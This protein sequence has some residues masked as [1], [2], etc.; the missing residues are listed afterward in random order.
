MAAVA[1]LQVAGL[2]NSLN[3]NWPL[4]EKAPLTS[5]AA[6]RVQQFATLAP[7]DNVLVILFDMV[8]SDL[9]SE[10][11]TLD[12]LTAQF[13]EGFVYFRN[14]A[15]LYTSTQFSA[16]SVLTSQSVPSGVDAFSWRRSVMAQSLPVLLAERGYETT[17]ASVAFHTVGCERGISG[18]RCLTLIRSR[19]PTSS[20]RSRR[21]GG[22]RSTCWR[23]WRSSGSCPT[24]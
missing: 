14:A 21:P 10:V 23:D 17:L 24:R 19:A 18:I 13:P 9:F 11:L 7:Q 1:L 3:E 12:D 22:R 15:S 20:G 2:A 4:V 8:Q 5:L 16:Q 6:P